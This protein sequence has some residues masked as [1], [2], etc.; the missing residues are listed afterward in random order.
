MTFANVLTAVLVYV[1]SQAPEEYE[2][3]PPLPVRPHADPTSWLADSLHRDQF[4]V[5]YSNPA[6]G[7]EYSPNHEA[8]ILWCEPGQNPLLCYGGEREKSAGKPWVR[9]YVLWSPQGTYLATIHNQ[10]IALWGGDRFMEQHRFAHAGVKLVSFSPCEK[11]LLTCNYDKTDR[12]F[13]IWDV[14]KAAAIRSFTKFSS[15]SNASDGSVQESPDFFKWSYDGSFLARKGLDRISIYELPGM[16]L[17]NKKSLK[18][19]GVEDFEWCPKELSIL[20]YWAPE[21][22]NTPA[23]VSVV[24]IP[25]G[26]DLRQKNL[27]NVS[28]CRLHWHSDGTYLCVKVLRHSKSKK[29][30][31][32]NFE[33]FRVR[34]PG[35]PIE[36]L[37]LRNEVMAFSWEPCGDRFAIIHGDGRKSDVTF[38]TMKGGE[39]G[40]EL[41]EVVTLTDI[42]ANHLYWSPQGQTILMAGVGE[43]S[44]GYLMFY[45]VEFQTILKEDEHYRLVYVSWDPSGRVVCTAINQLIE[46]GHY[47]AQMDNG[48]K[49]WTFQGECFY[50]YNKEQFYQ[51][52]WRPRPDSLLSLDE[53]KK[54]VKNLKKYERRFERADRAAARSKRRAAMA[55][56]VRKKQ[57]FREKIRSHN[58][59]VR[60]QRQELINIRGGYD[61]DDEIHYNLAEHMREVVVD[62]QVQVV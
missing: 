55:D 36:M 7:K 52:V 49:L 21:Q 14:R 46:G 35:V 2:S 11:Y 23:R 50:E 33:L 37:E 48:Y 26:K 38:W 42:P 31:Y 16:Q 58:D 62:V 51:F 60:A 22:D 17:L 15:T 24:D 5:R 47:K 56:K 53:H 8:E 41:T 40:D 3:P 61:S 9:L 44:R 13:I 45:D 34:D 6:K 25:S 30:M 59:A 57:E 1:Q 27:F 10:G 39:E 18:A 54:V 32:N 19:T 43:K 20:A 29:T 12:A 28:D 4:V